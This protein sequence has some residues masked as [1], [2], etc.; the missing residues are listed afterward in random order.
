MCACAIPSICDLLCTLQV[1]DL[2][3]EQRQALREQVKAL[4][5]EHVL[6]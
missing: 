6:A 3:L 2:L 1:F 4:M 5:L